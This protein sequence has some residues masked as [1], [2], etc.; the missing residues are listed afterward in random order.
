MY[1]RVRLYNLGFLIFTI[2]SVL[3]YLTPNTGYL[4]ALEIIIFRLVQAVGGAFLMVNS[5]ALLTDAFPPNE[6]GFALGTN[7]VAGLAGSLVG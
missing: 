6:R 7:Q 1:G 5:A 2:G 3:L 4:G